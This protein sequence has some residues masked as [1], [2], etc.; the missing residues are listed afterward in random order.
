MKRNRGPDDEAACTLRERED[1]GSPTTAAEAGCW[2]IA[3]E[4]MLAK[5]R[6]GDRKQARAFKIM[7]RTRKETKETKGNGNGNGI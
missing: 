6:G 5:R 3:S 7:P 4:V 1:E 2:F